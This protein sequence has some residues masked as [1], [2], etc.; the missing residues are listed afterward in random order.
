MLSAP[1]CPV[2]AIHAESPFPAF[3]KPNMKLH[4]EISLPC[5]QWAKLP[6]YPHHPL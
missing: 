6:T 1:F 3:T 5:D 2:M 4:E